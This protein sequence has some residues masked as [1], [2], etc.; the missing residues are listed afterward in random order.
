M[1]LAQTLKFKLVNILIAIPLLWITAVCLSQAQE[2]N[3]QDPAM[4]KLKIE[5]KS[6]VRLI[7]RREDNNEREEF[8][9]PDQIITLPTGKYCLQEVHLEGGYI[10]YASRGPKRLIASVTS[11]EPATLKIG[12]PLKQAVK[13]NRQGCHLVMNYELLGVG[14]EQYTGGNTGEPPTF[15]V[16]KGDKEIAS[17]KFE[18]G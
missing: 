13:V 6:I 2:T 5:G 15:T 1:I 11:D 9:R 14:G 18:F 16:Y 4:G 12:A 10:C 17:D 7:L 3:K 8:R